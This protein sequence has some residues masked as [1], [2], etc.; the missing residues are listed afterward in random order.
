MSTIQNTAIKEQPKLDFTKYLLNVWIF[1]PAIIYMVV[2]NRFIVNI[3]YQDDYDGVLRFLTDYKAASFGDKLGLL[4]RQHGEHRILSSRI[5]SILD[6]AIFG[7]VNFKHLVFLGNLQ[8]VIV[9]GFLV[10][11]IKKAMPKDWKIASFLLGFCIFDLSS[12]ENADFAI[13]GTVNYGILMLFFASLF[14]Y[15]YQEKKKTILGALFQVLAI[16]SSGVGIMTAVFVLLF[17][18]FGKNRLNIIVS[19][20]ILLVCAPLYFLH[21]EKSTAMGMASTPVTAAIISKFFFHLSGAHFGFDYSIP[22]SLVVFGLL[23]WVFPMSLKLKFKENTQSLV[24]IIGFLLGSVSLMA[25]MRSNTVMGEMAAY[26]SRY[27]IYSHLLVGLVIVLLIRKLSATKAYWPTVGV[28]AIVV[29]VAYKNNYQ[30]GEACLE[31]TKRRLETY[32]YYYGDHKEEAN[33]KA[34]KIEADACAAGIYCIQDER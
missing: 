30:Y 12:Y 13:A 8:L 25:L 14:F 32:P 19:A 20:A 2:V 33:K 3:P 18:I 4:F 17:N 23:V 9:F 16:Y 22:A 28:L 29:M 34:Q 11:F 15:S 10:M 1:I 31:M 6:A 5:Y 26:Q 21:Y 27:L 24:C 7:K